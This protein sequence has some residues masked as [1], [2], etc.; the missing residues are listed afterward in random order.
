[1]PDCNYVIKTDIMDTR[2]LNPFHTGKSNKNEFFGRRYGNAQLV[3]IIC[4]IISLGLIQLILK[5]YNKNLIM[6]LLLLYYIFLYYNLSC[7]I[8]PDNHERCFILAWICIIT[9][10]IITTII[11]FHNDIFKKKYTGGDKNIYYTFFG[12]KTSKN[13]G[14]NCNKNEKKN[15]K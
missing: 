6:I 4:A 11:L 2:F 1:M 9:I 3:F 12:K 5:D 7:Y 13:G 8:I 10:F 15:K 14:S